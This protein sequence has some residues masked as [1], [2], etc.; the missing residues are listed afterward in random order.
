MLVLSG[1]PP[2]F[3]LFSVARPTQAKTLRRRQWHIFSNNFYFNLKRNVLR[4][5][6]LVFSLFSFDSNNDV[7]FS[8]FH[9]HHVDFVATP[10]CFQTLRILCWGTAPPSSSLLF[11]CYFCRFFFFLRPTD[12]KSEN[13][14]DNKWKKGDGLVT[15]RPIRMPR[16]T[17]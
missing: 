7:D 8:F 9:C 6:F 3:S 12:P 1:H 5:R 4:Y 13:S 14:F 17:C 2:F 15:F 11:H 10:C 16:E